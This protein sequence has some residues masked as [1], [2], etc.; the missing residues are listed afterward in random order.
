MMP[1]F[2]SRVAWEGEW[3][4]SSLIVYEW[5]FPRFFFRYLWIEVLH[6]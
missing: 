4:T 3:P 1:T 5:E 2:P 6:L